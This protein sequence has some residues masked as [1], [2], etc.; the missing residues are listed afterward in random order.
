MANH[1]TILAWEIPWKRSLV[2]Y[3]PCGRKESDM[4][5]QLTHTSSLSFLEVKLP[6]SFYFYQVPLLCLLFL[7]YMILP[8]FSA[9]SSFTCY[10]GV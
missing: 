4:T 6:E 1:S 2:G 7:L 10:I 5:G 3:S 8:S 9:E